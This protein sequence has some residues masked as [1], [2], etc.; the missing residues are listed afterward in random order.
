MTDLGYAHAI[1]RVTG[2]LER[3]ATS[4]SLVPLGLEPQSVRLRVQTDQEPPILQPWQ[5]TLHMFLDL[6]LQAII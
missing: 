5:C 1:E 6:V 3:A 4:N 2:I